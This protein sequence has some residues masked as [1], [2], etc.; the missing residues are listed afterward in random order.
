M[1][2]SATNPEGKRLRWFV[3]TA[4][5]QIKSSDKSVEGAKNRPQLVR[6]MPEPPYGRTKKLDLDSKWYQ[7]RTEGILLG[8]CHLKTTQH[9]LSLT[10]FTRFSTLPDEK[11]FFYAVYF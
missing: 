4:V 10:I 6:L 7:R 8:E 1:K 5:D 9:F 3:P 11:R 2:T